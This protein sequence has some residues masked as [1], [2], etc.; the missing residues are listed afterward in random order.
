[1]WKDRKEVSPH[2]PKRAKTGWMVVLLIL[3]V[4]VIWLLEGIA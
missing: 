2:R 3:V 4:V 1:M